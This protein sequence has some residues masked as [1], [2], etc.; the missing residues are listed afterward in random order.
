MTN[1]MCAA[2]RRKGL[3]ALL[4]VA[5]SLKAALFNASYSPGQTTYSTTNESTGTGYTAGGQAVSGA[6]NATGTNKAYGTISNPSWTGLTT[7]TAWLQIYDVTDSNSVVVEVDLG[8]TQTVAG[9][10]FTINMPTADETHALLQ[11]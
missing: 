11:V 6:T 7:T 1:T 3:N 10:T 8:G 5:N 2:R 9:A 4:V